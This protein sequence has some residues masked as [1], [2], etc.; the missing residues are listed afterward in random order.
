MHNRAPLSIGSDVVVSQEVLITTGSHAF[1]TDMATTSAPITVHDG[2]WLTSRA[3]ILAGSVIET[4]A[5]VLPNTV[6]HGVVPA[7]SMFG[8]PTGN[9][10]G[11]RFISADSE[12][13]V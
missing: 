12:T 1:R 7:G 2:A 8:I 4:S 11:K 5:L 6:V 3:V 9:V 13:G 10:V